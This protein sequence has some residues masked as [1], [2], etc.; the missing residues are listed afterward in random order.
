MAKIKPLKKSGIFS[1]LSDRELALFSRI[2]TEDECSPDTVLVAENMKSERF[3]FIEKGRVSL[4]L[5][6]SDSHEECGLSDGDTFGEWAILAP[7]HLTSVSV[8]VA[9]TSKILVLKSEDFER[10]AGEEPAIAFKIQKDLIKR[11]WPLMEDI[12][13][14]LLGAEK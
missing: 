10:F 14:V 8:R 5:K 11:A 9:E 7:E 6:N 3:F 4:Q 1:S 12:K 2:L 13:T